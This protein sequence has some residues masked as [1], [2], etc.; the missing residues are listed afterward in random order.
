MAGPLILMIRLHRESRSRMLNGLTRTATRMLSSRSDD[1][2]A[3]SSASTS[4]RAALSS[5]DSNSS[6]LCVTRCYR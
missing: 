6:S 1:R 3:A 2:S 4:N 5:N